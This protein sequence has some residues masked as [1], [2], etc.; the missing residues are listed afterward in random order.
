MFWKKK[1]EKQQNELLVTI[2][3]DKYNIDFAGRIPN[4]NQVFVTSDLHY[5]ATLK[6]TT[7][8]VV[9]YVWDEPGNFVEG[10]VYV[11]GVRGEYENADA[12]KL[13]D[14]IKADYTNFEPGT[15]SVKPCTFVHDGIE[16]G[17]IPRIEDDYK[18]VEVMPG[19]CLCFTEPFD[20]SY[21]T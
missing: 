20:G 19:N 10:K 8:F 3:P 21:D 4:G 12:A 13:Q 16:F 7:D 15:I 9:E 11:V 1:K 6:T 5:D 18:V 2:V 14:K 17:F